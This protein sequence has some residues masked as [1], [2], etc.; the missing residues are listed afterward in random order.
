MERCPDC[1][2]SQ[3]GSSAITGGEKLCLMLLVNFLLELSQDCWRVIAERLLP[4]FPVG[5]MGVSVAW[6]LLEKTKEHGVSLFLIFV[7]LKKAYD[8]VPRKYPVVS[9]CE[10]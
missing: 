5:V 3:E 4:R 2:F 8:S 9:S 6:Q 10:V 7:N 1:A